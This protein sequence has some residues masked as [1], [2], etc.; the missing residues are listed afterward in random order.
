MEYTLTRAERLGKKDFRKAKWTKSGR[1]PNFLLFKSK[2]KDM[3]KRFGV[4]VSRKIKGSIRRNRIKR[5]LREFF[6]LN[7]QLF[8]EQVNYSVRVMTMSAGVR[9]DDVCRELHLLVAKGLSK[10]DENCRISA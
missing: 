6:R 10:N 4:V 2:N 9:W 5:L 8:Q 3:E 1:T 7:K